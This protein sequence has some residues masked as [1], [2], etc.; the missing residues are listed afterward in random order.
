LPEQIH[1][2]LT[3]FQAGVFGVLGVDDLHDTSPTLTKRPSFL[4][5]YDFI[6]RMEVMKVAVVVHH[7]TVSKLPI[8]LW[9]SLV[10]RGMA[11]LEYLQT[12]ER[13]LVPDADAMQALKKIPLL[14]LGVQ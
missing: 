7:P 6:P 3:F 2:D 11:V 12:Q 5:Y 13:V 1:S 10:A 4:G 9:G 14:L 8:T